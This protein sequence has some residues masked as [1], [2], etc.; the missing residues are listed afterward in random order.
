MPSPVD[1]YYEQVKEHNP[2]YS[3]EQVW[4]TAWS[5]Y[6]KHKNPGSP[7]CHKDPSEYL[8]GKKATLLRA[9]EDALLTRRVAARF[10]F[11]FE[12]KETKEHKAERLAKKIRD[13]TGLSKS[14]SEA[15][16]DAYVRGREVARLAIQKGWPIEGNVIEGPSG[17]FSLD[18]A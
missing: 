1:K 15:I 7:S 9:F 18:A 3:E 16:A 14:I 5:I 6:C 12:P 8:K 4:A 11:K 17:T 2:A 10:A 13:A